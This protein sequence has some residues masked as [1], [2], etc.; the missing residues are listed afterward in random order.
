MPEQAPPPGPVPKEAIK[1][2]KA[3]KLKPGFSYLDVWGEEHQTA[4][5]V[6]KVMRADILNDVQLSLLLALEEGETFKV[7]A[8]GI[9]GTL[10]KGGW[11][12]YH[13][14]RSA[15]S[16]LSVIFDTNMRGARS[17]GQWDRIERTKEFRPYLT[18]TLGPS[19]RHRPH[20]ASW[21]GVTL[22]ATDTWWDSHTPQNGFRCLCGLSQETKRVAER[23]G[24]ERVKAGKRGGILKKA[25]ASPLVT[26]KHPKTG[27]VERIPV[28]IDPGFNHNPG[29]SVHRAKALGK[30]LK[31]SEAQQTKSRVA[32]SKAVK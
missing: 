9:K 13:K 31:T 2:L 12:N 27:K 20:H 22:P 21:E 1:Y 7:W 6:A 18:Y 26:W 3:K 23:R 25:P 29:K 32:V 30:S 19:E 4:F 8:E 15:V 14:E 11:S 5:T 24:A 28:G 16:R 17:V 10:D